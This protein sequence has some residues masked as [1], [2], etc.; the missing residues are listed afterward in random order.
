MKKTLIPIERIE[1]G[2]M[3][4]TGQLDITRNA[5]LHA[6]DNFTAVEVEN[7]NPTG[8]KINLNIFF[9]LKEEHCAEGC[10]TCQVWNESMKCYQKNIE[11]GEHNNER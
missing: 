3:L 10:I 4:L 11:E 5:N 1:Y 7:G 6:G 2:L 8:R 9:T